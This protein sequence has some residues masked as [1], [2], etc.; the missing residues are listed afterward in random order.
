MQNR[1][2]LV[3]GIGLIT[4][5]IIAIF[6]TLFQINLW[7]ILLP[8]LIIGIGL[9]IVFR[10]KTLDS[11]TNFIFKP[12][13]DIDFLNSWQVSPQEIWFFVGSVELDFSQA[14]IPEGI[15]QIKLFSFVGDIRIREP[16][17]AG[18]K[19]SSKAFITDSKVHG[20]KQDHFLNTLNYTN[21]D[22]DNQSKKVI[23]DSWFFVGEIRVES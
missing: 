11:N 5:G 15:T 20:H 10:P 22:Y 7:S 13:G 9:L 17:S 12:L 2:T 6:N 23:V 1:T 19:V 16:K 14:I 18:L 4:L 8:L 3:I 21:P